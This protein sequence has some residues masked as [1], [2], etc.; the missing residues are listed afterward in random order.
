MIRN[1]SSER[2]KAHTHTLILIGSALESALESAYSS[3]ESADSNACGY[4]MVGHVSIIV[5]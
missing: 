3:S 4:V 2:L 5:G 1:T